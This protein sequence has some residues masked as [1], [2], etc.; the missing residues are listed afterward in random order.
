M[1]FQTW[2][3]ENNPA[4]KQFRIDLVYLRMA[5]IWAENSYCKRCQVGC[6]IVK[7][8][9]IISDGYNG[10]PTG[11]PNECED[12]NN[13][14]IPLVLHAEAN[15][16]TKLS[17]STISSVGSTIYLTLSPCYDCAKLII[18]AGIKRVVFKEIYRNTSAFNLFE[19]AN[20]EAI[21]IKY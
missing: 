9:T 8:R 10:T 5:E 19:T 6:L 4:E 3:R 14:T 17:K 18:Q 2:S 12:K 11:F 13:E 1:I 15:A 20:I 16:I 21:N 7:D